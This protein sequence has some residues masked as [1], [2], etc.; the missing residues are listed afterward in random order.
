MT[1]RDSPSSPVGC[2]HYNVDKFWY[3]II[4]RYNRYVE[5]DRRVNIV[6]YVGD[7]QAKNCII[8]LNSNL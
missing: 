6:V 2:V 3:H 8:Y 4:S 7:G 5:V 1:D